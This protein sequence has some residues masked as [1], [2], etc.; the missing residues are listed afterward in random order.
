MDLSSEDRFKN[1]YYNKTQSSSYKYKYK[2]EWL[3][4]TILV[5]ITDGWHL[6]Q[7]ISH[8]T[9]ILGILLFNSNLNLIFT[10]IILKSLHLFTFEM[11]YR[12]YKKF[13]L[14]RRAS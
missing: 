12:H 1:P 9:F 5:F 13:L 3:F 10:F 2:P 6:F 7:F 11:V 8:S 4:T 14:H